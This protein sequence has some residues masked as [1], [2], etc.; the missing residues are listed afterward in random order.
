VSRYCR[1]GCRRHAGARRGRGSQRVD[2][3]G[4]ASRRC[5]AWGSDPL[6]DITVDS[7][8]LDPRASYIWH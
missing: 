4:G 2:G 6:L 8:N 7:V 1:G 3:G 5:T